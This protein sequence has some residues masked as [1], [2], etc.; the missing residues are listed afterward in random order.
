MGNLRALCSLCNLGEKDRAPAPPQYRKIMSVLRPAREE[1][2]RMVLDFLLK[3]FGTSEV[4]AQGDLPFF[5]R[6]ND[7]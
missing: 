6:E 5:K 7:S 1:T 2:Q 3:K 4:S